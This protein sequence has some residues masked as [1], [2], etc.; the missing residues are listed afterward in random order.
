[1][2]GMLSIGDVGHAAPLE[3]LSA[4]I[5]SVSAHHM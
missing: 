2:I 3:L 4:C 1:M 5:K